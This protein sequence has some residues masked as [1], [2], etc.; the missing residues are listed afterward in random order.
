MKKKT[1]YSQ[2]R[3]YR[4]RGIFITPKYHLSQKTKLLVERF[5]HLN[6]FFTNLLLTYSLF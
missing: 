5:K 1:N 4:P 6:A 3:I 2:L